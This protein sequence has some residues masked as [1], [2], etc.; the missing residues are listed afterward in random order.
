MDIVLIAGFLIF[1]G[2]FYFI[3]NLNPQTGDTVVIKVN[4]K[5]YAEVSLNDEKDVEIYFDDGT[6]SNT[7]RI[8]DNKASMIYAACPDK[9]CMRYKPVESQSYINNILVCLPN[10]VTVELKTDG[11]SKNKNEV[12]VII[13]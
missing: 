11:K 4:G 5:I 8:Q 9:L 13:R 3:L 10:R 1:A 12:D 2:M 7:V 6:I